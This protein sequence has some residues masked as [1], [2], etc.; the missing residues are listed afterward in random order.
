M[1][2][3]HALLVLAALL[4][5]FHVVS[6]VARA[7]YFAP[8]THDETHTVACADGWRIAVHRVRPTNPDP[9]KLPV[10]L[11]HGLGANRFN[12]NFPGRYSLAR[13]LADRGYDA[14]VPD[15]R[16]GGHSA[17]RRLF[18]PVRWDYGFL[19]HV[20][21]DLPAMIA[22]VRR[23]TGKNAVHWVG[24]S[25][26]GMV[27]YAFAQRPDAAALASICAIGSPGHFE[28]LA[29]LRGAIR[30]KFLLAPFPAIWINRIF[31]AF[32]PAV[33]H[34]EP[35]FI[36]DNYNPA[37]MAARTARVAGANLVTPISRTLLL[38]FASFV[39]TGRLVGADG[40]DYAAGLAK[41]TRPIFLI[42]GSV[43]Q[44][45]PRD[46]IEHV[47]AR[48]ASTDKSYRCFGKEFGDRA[49]YGHGDLLLGEAA[50]DEI[51]PAVAK[52]LEA[53]DA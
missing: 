42:A 49:D 30:F 39:A 5:L 36:T 19:D 43:D 6:Y 8:D 25:M 41:I 31:G 26:G 22:H 16:G 35:K 45:A 33:G 53:H 23:V 4:A 2:L 24:H 29:H 3:L 38:D 44:L 32:I 52:W 18:D 50:P 20:E 7:A 14:Y 17:R 40:T 11:C 37:N 51:F 9:K 34:W 15:L 10:I 28:R 48:V 27:A 13:Y 21:R 47:L 46:C 12:L 1:I